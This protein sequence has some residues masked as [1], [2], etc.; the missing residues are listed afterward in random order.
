MISKWYWILTNKKFFL[1]CLKGRPMPK[2]PGPLLSYEQF[3]EPWMRRGWPFDLFNKKMA[4]LAAL[5]DDSD[6]E[7][8]KGLCRFETGMPAMLTAMPSEDWGEKIVKNLVERLQETAAKVEEYQDEITWNHSPG[9]WSTR[10]FDERSALWQDLRGLNDHID[11]VDLASLAPLA[12]RCENRESF[13]FELK[14]LAADYDRNFSQ[15]LSLCRW[16]PPR[17]SGAEGPL[18]E[19]FL[20]DKDNFESL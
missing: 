6:L 3:A 2:M 1:G 17:E 16:T 13:I 18:P 9:S 11:H 19:V 8:H 10:S 5:F 7:V 4:L 20:V 14:S 12:S 15:I